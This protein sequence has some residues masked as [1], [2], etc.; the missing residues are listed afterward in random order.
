M[1][2]I[3]LVDRKASYYR[4]HPGRITNSKIFYKAQNKFSFALVCKKVESTNFLLSL[5]VSKKSTENI[6]S[7]TY[8][9][10]FWHYNQPWSLLC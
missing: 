5:L 2:I 6:P 10:D 1:V 9:S 4:M 7:E 8:W 3:G